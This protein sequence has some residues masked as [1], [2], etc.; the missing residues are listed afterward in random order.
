MLKSL[1]VQGAPANARD[2]QG[3]NTLHLNADHIGGFCRLVCRCMRWTFFLLQAP[4][5][6]QT[7]SIVV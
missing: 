6:L 4:S 2:A 5:C 1:L 3:C 7:S